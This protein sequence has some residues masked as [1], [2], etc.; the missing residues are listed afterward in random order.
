MSMY[1]VKKVI[2]LLLTLL[3][4]SLVTFAAFSVIP[5]DAALL[6]VSTST[7][8]E[9][10]E[11][12]R[13]EM[14]LNDPLPVRYV[15]W[16]GNVLKGDFGRSSYYN[17]PVSGLLSEKLPVSVGLSLIA[18]LFIILISIPLAVIAVKRENGILDRITVTLGRVMMAVPSF[19]LGLLIILIFGFTLKAFKVG[20]Y[21]SYKNDM[22][23]FVRYM[24]FPAL[25]I[26]LPKIAQTT[27]FL[28]TNLIKELN[29][30][31]IKTL[32]SAGLGEFRILFHALKNA[33]L[34]TMTFIGLVMAEVLAGSVIIEQVFGIPGIGRLL[35]QSV[36]TRD[37]FVTQAI[38]L[39]IGS[40]VV[41]INFV[42]DMLYRVF[43][44]TVRG[45]KE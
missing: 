31:Y 29:K 45:G 21:V 5:G 19:F 26:A 36:Q 15:R 25:A 8:P 42:T 12:L 43:D 34:P 41:I 11:S 2:A 17:R 33:M 3:I 30:N 22:N 40:A 38:V 39:Y 16:V 27:V 4:V 18:I 10:L 23:G 28:R 14:G 7:D 35:V 44:P 13:Q 32:R 24:I 37:L 6:K 20:G 9:K 1:Y